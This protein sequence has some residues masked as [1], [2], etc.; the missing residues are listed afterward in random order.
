MS[1]SSPRVMGGLIT[2][3][4]FRPKRYQP[5]NSTWS[6]H[7]PFANDIVAATR[8]RVLVELGTHFGESY[9][10]FCQ[11][12]VENHVECQC[13]SIDTWL[14][15]EH[16]GFYGEHVFEEVS[17]YNRD[18]YSSFS[19]LLRETFDSA[20]L[21]FEAGTIDLLH[22]DGL[23]TYEDVR[24][25]FETWL[26]KVRAGGIILIH[27][28]QERRENFG[29]WKF[30][31][32]L[33]TQ[34][35]HFEFLHSCGLGVLQTG[36][37]EGDQP[38]LLRALFSAPEQDHPWVRSH[39]A[40]AAEKLEL[41]H[42]LAEARHQPRI[43]VF[44]GRDGGFK[45]EYSRLAD[46]E[47]GVWQSHEFV[48]TEGCEAGGL[49][50]D[51]AD[52]PAEIDLAA[53]TLHRLGDRTPILQLTDPGIL[54]SLSCPRHLVA[55][56]AE[57]VATF[58]SYG[59]DPQLLVEPPEPN[60][61]HQPLRVE[62]R[63]RV[64]LDLTKTAEWI[65]RGMTSWGGAGRAE[66]ERLLAVQVETLRAEYRQQEKERLVV[67][68]E[69]REL[70]AT[71]QNLEAQVEDLRDR[72]RR[73]QD[74]RVELEARNAG[75]RDAHQAGLRQQHA[76][77]LVFTSEFRRLVATKQSLEVQIEDSLDRLRR[78][79]DVRIARETTATAKLDRQLNALQ[80]ELNAQQAERHAL[81]AE[82][83]ALRTERHNLRAHLH[84]E[85]QR[86]LDLE[87]S[88]SWRATRPVRSILK[89]LHFGGA[90]RGGN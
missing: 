40:L 79:Q 33:K 78:E 61:F 5:G 20:S 25:D 84:D 82:R 75:L 63:M 41:S 15:D 53:I 86:R 65:R 44:T 58:F 37:A 48:F 56:P 8:P 70:V 80:S 32:E 45:E 38:A 34:Y 17:K 7:L 69:F 85:R 23:H 87:H 72:L 21:R 36:A 1:Q 16:A 54:V 27:D 39:Y 13:Y 76:E 50:I 19:I 62:I 10:G 47:P 6:G 57:A 74:L 71:K 43:Q 90:G 60:A 18:Y 9:F 29:V 11:A 42:K 2:T 28:T 81:R 83:D 31:A 49:R 51:L 67:T 66:M 26:P 55:L 14:G 73:E 30:W 12:V 22:I 24:H 4:E 35:P 52:C 59:S 64:C 89:F 88:Y 68:S 3:S 77:R 46:I